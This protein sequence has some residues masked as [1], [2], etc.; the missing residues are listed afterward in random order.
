MSELHLDCDGESRGVY[1]RDVDP[2]A[3]SPNCCYRLLVSVFA[4][5][6]TQRQTFEI[7]NVKIMFI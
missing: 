7:I 6:Q 5:V 3:V 2:Y 4:F 1:N